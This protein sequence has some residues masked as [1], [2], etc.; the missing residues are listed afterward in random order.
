M[1]NRSMKSC[2]PI[3][4][5]VAIIAF[6]SN[7][8]ASAFAPV[9][10]SSAYNSV[11]PT[12]H[13][14]RIR[15]GA[16]N[17]PSSIKKQRK[18]KASIQTKMGSQALV[19]GTAVAATFGLQTIG[20][21]AAWLLKTETFYDIFGGANYLIL[22]LLSAILGATGDGLQWIDDPRKI[23]TTVLFACS[24][25]WL[26]LFLAWRAHERKGD[27]R[28]DEVLGKNGN[29]P[30]AGNFFVF[31]VAQAFWVLLVSMPMLFVNSS[32]VMKPN[33]SGYDIAWAMLFGSGV[34]IEIISDIQKA[35]WVKKGRQGDFCEA[36]VWKYSRHP[37]YF[38]EIF[39][40]WCLFAFSYSSSANPL[41][42]YADPL[43]WLGIVSPLFTMQILLT[44]QPTGI[45]NAEGKNLK[46]Y[47]DKCPERYAK[48]RDN[49][50]ILIPFVGYNFVPQFLKRTIFFDFEKYE[51]KPRSSDSAEDVAKKE[52]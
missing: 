46:R 11:L 10:V 8:N 5:A 33:F 41:G 17:Q 2:L 45:C 49:T 32:S 13:L 25:G 29:P 1:N 20:F 12:H 44:M 9:R 39:Q 14:E 30:Q 48:Y 40:W 4:H 34:F 16:Q 26:L 18:S 23:L 19:Y 21:I 7:S 31:W 3:L 38:G 52:E 28:F 36:G 51:Y 35:I 22:A 50:S 27:S 24:R 47:Y 15:G 6:V 42:G 37:N 43:W